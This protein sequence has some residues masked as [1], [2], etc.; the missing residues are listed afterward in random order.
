MY[1]SYLELI[2]LE[3]S[4]PFPYNMLSWPILT[5]LLAGLAEFFGYAKMA[6]AI[7]EDSGTPRFGGDGAVFSPSNGKSSTSA[8]RK[9]E[10][11]ILE[12]PEEEPG[13]E[14]GPSSNLNV[15][16][17]PSVLS[18]SGVVSNSPQPISNT[19][20]PAS[21]PRQKVADPEVDYLNVKQFQH[22]TAP[23]PVSW[24]RENPAA[25]NASSLDP[26]ML[27][28]LVKMDISGQSIPLDQQPLPTAGATQAGKPADDQLAAGASS[29]PGLNDHG[30]FRKDTILS[31]QE[32]NA[33]LELLGTEDM[34]GA[35]VSCAEHSLQEAMEQGSSKPFKIEWI[36]V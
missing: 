11:S 27:A 28:S 21:P 10:P 3:V 12:T 33:R 22:N 13:E 18:P 15:P 34:S 2:N 8:A 32:R 19:T 31:P 6:G 36:R 7:Q 17:V 1:S 14:A 26:S 29:R 5:L 25:R 4:G 35:N 16:V 23:S 24:E 30:V 9:P 20:T